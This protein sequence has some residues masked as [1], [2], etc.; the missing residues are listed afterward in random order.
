[1]YRVKEGI[2]GCAIADALTVPTK[3]LESSSSS[4][5]E[6]KVV[7]ANIGNSIMRNNSLFFI[8]VYFKVIT[9]FFISPRLFC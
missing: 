5:H 7:T 8:L 3:G 9:I 4:P 2:L 1:M 6:V